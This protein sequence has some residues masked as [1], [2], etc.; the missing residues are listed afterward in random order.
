MIV[1]C[2]FFVTSAIGFGDASFSLLY[3]DFATVFDASMA[4]TGWIA[5]FNL[6]TGSYLGR[7][8]KCFEIVMQICNDGGLWIC[9]NDSRSTTRMSRPY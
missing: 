8:A 7:L 2:A 3:V 1:F 9:S 6:G 5:A 4:A